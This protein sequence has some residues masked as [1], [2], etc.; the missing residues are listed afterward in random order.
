[1]RRGFLCL[2]LFLLIAAA[3]PAQWFGGGG[4]KRI[5]RATFVLC[6]GIP[7]SV[8]SDLTNH[9]IVT[10]PG[11]IK[12][13][14]LTAK[15]PPTGVSLLF[16]VLKN[17]STNIFGATPVGLAP[18]AQGPLKIS[19]TPVSVAELNYLTVNITQVGSGAPGQDVTLVCLIE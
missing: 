6:N 8:G 17:G 16:A 11:K 13:C 9:Y 3:A 5:E 18:G 19:F 12:S 1:M 10:S 7:C 14:Y 4:A 2:V 15:T